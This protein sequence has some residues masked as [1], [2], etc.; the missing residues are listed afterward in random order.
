MYVCPF[1]LVV[2][3]VPRVIQRRTVLRWGVRLNNCRRSQSRGK[4]V[5][6]QTRG[7]SASAIFPSRLRGAW[8]AVGGVFSLFMAGL[9]GEKELGNGSHRQRNQTD[10]KADVETVHQGHDQN[11]KKEGEFHVGEVR[12]NG[13]NQNEEPLPWWLPGLRRGWRWTAQ[14]PALSCE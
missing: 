2:G 8:A 5:T 14:R 9:G 13:G 7:A 1:W 4:S 3:T 10:Q 6:E 12:V 11:Q